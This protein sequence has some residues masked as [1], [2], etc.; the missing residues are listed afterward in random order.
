MKAE[1]IAV[2][3]I[4]GVIA[5]VGLYVV[6][7]NASTSSVTKVPT[8]TAEKDNSVGWVVDLIGIFNKR[9]KKAPTTTLASPESSSRVQLD[10]YVANGPALV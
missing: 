2:I 4:V 9:K 7:H 8:D 1:N 10:D 5:L 3:G 6:S